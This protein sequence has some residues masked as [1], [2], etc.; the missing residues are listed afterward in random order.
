M[1]TFTLRFF[2][3]L[4]EQ[5]GISELDIP[6]NAAGSLSQLKRYVLQEYPQWQTIL[7]GP[8]L[9]AVNQTMV[10]GDQEL[11]QG[12]EVAWFPPVTGG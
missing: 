10:T 1:A 2:A 7:S 3:R 11:A 6:L 9:V 12:D 5:T 8:I 4:R